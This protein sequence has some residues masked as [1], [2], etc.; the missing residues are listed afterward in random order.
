MQR[1]YIDLIKKATAKWPNW[2]PL[3]RIYVSIAISSWSVAARFDRSLTKQA[4]DFGTIKKETGEL[5]VEGNIYT[6]IDIMMIASQHPVVS[7]P[8]VDQIEIHSHEVREVDTRASA[9][10]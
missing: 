6:H 9:G 7:P 10:A 8:D 4:G 3:K 2:D 5:L 1:K